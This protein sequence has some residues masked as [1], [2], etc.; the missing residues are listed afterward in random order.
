MSTNQYA[1]VDYRINSLLMGANCYRVTSGEEVFDQ[2]L[3]EEISA[4]MRQ[5][6]GRCFM[7]ARMEGS[8]EEFWMVPFAMGDART[9]ILI[10]AL[11]DVMNYRAGSAYLRFPLDV[12][13]DEN[14]KVFLLRPIDRSLYVPIRKF[15]P[16]PEAPRWEIAASLFR[17]VSEMQ[18]MGITSNGLSREQLRV[19]SENNEVAIWLNETLSLLEDS[20]NRKNVTRHTGFF[21]IPEKTEQRCRQNGFVIDGGKRDVFS[22]AAAAF[23]LI[24]YTHPFVGSAF[25]G[26]MHNEY[27]NYYQID[28]SYIME[29]NSENNPGNQMLSRAV[30]GQWDRTVPELKA[31]FDGIFLAVTH[32]DRLWDDAAPYWDPREWLRALAADAQANDNENS[33]MT[34]RFENEMYHLV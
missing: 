16:A 28:P 22:A 5:T 27:L 29:A 23:Y 25:Y 10:N 7:H 4:P 17:R 9:S 26:L 33:R 12:A 8:S 3:M 18:D 31:L 6:P 2:S 15:M 13:A 30:M 14:E 20:R 34:F 24:M 21:S 32:P 19:N 11:E 1:H